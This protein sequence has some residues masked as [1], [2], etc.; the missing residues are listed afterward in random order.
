MNASGRLSSAGRVRSDAARERHRTAGRNGRGAGRDSPARRPQDSN[1]THRDKEQPAAPRTAHGL[2][3][4][5]QAARERAQQRCRGAGSRAHPCP[6]Y[7]H[8]RPFSRAA[9]GDGGT[10]N[11]TRTPRSRTGA[12]EWAIASAV[13]LDEARECHVPFRECR[14]RA[15]AS[16]SVGSPHA[17]ALTNSS[18]YPALFAGLRMN[19]FCAR[20]GRTRALAW[21]CR[22]LPHCCRDFAWRRAPLRESHRSRDGRIRTGDPLLPKQVRYQAAP[23]PVSTKGYGQR[24]TPPHC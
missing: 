16:T 6:F 12:R 23:R 5:E 24:P 13:A 17:C 10:F 1:R 11:P 18:S 9:D 14:C 15:K 22:H 2:T 4:L 21:L 7:R 19:L 20:Y 8:R 3:F